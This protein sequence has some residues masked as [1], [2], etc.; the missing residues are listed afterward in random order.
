MACETVDLP[1]LVRGRWERGWR[2]GDPAHACD[3]LPSAPLSH[4]TRS[5]LSPSHTRTHRQSN[6]TKSPTQSV[7]RGEERRA[8][9]SG[10]DAP[11]PKTLDQLSHHSSAVLHTALFCRQLGIVRP[12]PARAPS[13]DV[14]YATCGDPRVA[15]TVADRSAAVAAW[16]RKPRTRPA[17]ATVT[18]TL[19]E[20]RKRLTSGWPFG[21]GG[22][23]GASGDDGEGSTARVPWER[24]VLPLRV[25][26]RHATDDDALRS[27]ADPP[28][29]AAGLEACLAAAA[30]AAA[31]RTD[32]VPPVVAPD[33]P[34]F[35]FD[36]AWA[37]A[38]GGSG[39]DA[40]RR[41]LKA[42]PPPPVLT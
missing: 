9:G 17:R 34:P 20:T 18:L 38:G 27:P 26:P 32:H 33:G 39:L 41:L 15:A 42:A 8:A 36:V 40:V 23:G 10:F 19:Q 2:A 12:S 13:L 28:P 7:V 1:E 30:L 4:Q 37:D 14:A 16:A 31:A 22:G 11:P 25:V 24:W 6:P 3:A 29:G 35:P 5:L 21:G